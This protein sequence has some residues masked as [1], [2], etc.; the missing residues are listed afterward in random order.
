MTRPRTHTWMHVLP[1]N[2]AFDCRAA[3]DWLREPLAGLDG[4][5]GAAQRNVAVEYNQPF[6]ETSASALVGINCPAVKGSALAKAGFSIINQFAVLPSWENPRWFIPLGRPA[7][8]SAGF[9][10]YTP[11]RTTARL[12]RLAA[13]ILV[14]ARLPFW[15]RDR[16]V[17]AQRQPSPLQQAMLDLFPGR[18]L[19]LALSSGAPEG[20]RNRKVS[21]AAIDSNGTIL[22]FL[23]IA[24]TPLARSLLEREAENLR[25]LS[26]MGG[27]ADLVPRLLF[28]GE[29]DGFY[30][31]VQVP[32]A[33]GVAPTPIGPIHLAL[34]SKLARGPVAEVAMTRLVAEL[35][36]RLATLPQPHPELSAALEQALAGLENQRIATGVVHGDFA[37]WNLRRTGQTI[38]AFDWEYGHLDGPAGFDEIHYRLQVGYLLHDWTLENAVAALT[39]SDLLSRY[40]SQPTRSSRQALLMLY[41]V[42]M[43]ARLFGE[44]YDRANDMVDWHAQLLEGLRESTAKETVLT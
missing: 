37:P 5:R 43:L 32:L 8:T 29:I 36:A 44:G 22:A 7:V 3:P 20:A 42:D 41:L 35:P 21:A 34:L 30:T 33:G 2:A 16:L 13:R 1:R 40:L 14:H 6:S 38:R 12:K 28:S 24:G 23:K 9:D 27:L 10:L 39:G 25:Q 15:F 31:T 4:A 17:I 26:S 11:A 18:E 19:S